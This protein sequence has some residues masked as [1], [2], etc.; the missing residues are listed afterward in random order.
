[1][2]IIGMRSKSVDEMS[3]FIV[4]EMIGVFKEKVKDFVVKNEID[5]AN[6]KS[7]SVEFGAY[8]YFPVIFNYD[9]GRMGCSI[10]F[11]NRTMELNNSQQWWDEAD[12]DLFFKE[13]QTELELR[14]PDKFLKAH[15]WL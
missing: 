1:M 15:G 4:D 9:M 3:D 8:D 2:E 5:E 10:C 13:L 12:F 6:H 11:G 14:I 7:F